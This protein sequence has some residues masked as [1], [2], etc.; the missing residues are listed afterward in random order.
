MYAQLCSHLI[1]KLPSFPPDEAEPD[2]KDLKF[3]QLLIN[4]CQEAFEGSDTLNADIRQLAP[5]EQDLERMTKLRTLGN[6]CFIGELFKEKI[7]NAKIVHL[8]VQVLF[9]TLLFLD[10]RTVVSYR[11]YICFK[12]FTVEF[13]RSL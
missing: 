2:G 6:I 1:T 8:V 10:Q 5:P 3:H 12:I 11:V 4:K 7:V 13:D 9:A